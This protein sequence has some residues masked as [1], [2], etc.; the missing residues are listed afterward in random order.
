MKIALIS[1]RIDPFISPVD[2]NGGCVLVR[3]YIKSLH[4]LGHDIHVFTRLDIEA[5]NNTERQNKKAQLQKDAGTGKI[6]VN[7][8][9][10][11]YRLPYKALDEKN[12]TWEAQVNESASFLKNVLPYLESEKFDVYHYF[13]LLSLA[14]WRLLTG[15]IP[16]LEK[17]T[18]SPLLISAGRKFEYLEDA[19]VAYERT[20]METMPVISCQSS[21][22]LNDIVTQYNIDPAKLIHVPLGVDTNI[23]YPKKDFLVPLTTNKRIL[24]SPNTLKPQKKQ[25]EVVDIVT[26]LVKNGHNL[27]CVFIGRVREQEYLDKVVDRI[28]SHKMSIKW[29]DEIPTRETLLSV[30]ENFI[31]IPGKKEKELANLIRSSDIAIFPSTDEGFGLLNLDCMACGT[32]PVCSQIKAYEDYLLPGENALAVDPSTGNEGFIS[33]VDSLLV[34]TDKLIHLSKIAANSSHNFSWDVLIKKQLHVYNQLNDGVNLNTQNYKD[35]N[36]VNL[37]DQ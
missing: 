27:V 20:V 4:R 5:P 3:N 25:L 31:Y 19:R 9:L 33:A 35:L 22:E 10:T 17:S 2:M 7:N 26:E 21:G 30:A 12:K 15:S 14:G 1:A 13:H 37:N 23:F 8:R 24:I 29:L 6:S 32:L 36:W 34:D 11:I 16:F 28:A 18:F